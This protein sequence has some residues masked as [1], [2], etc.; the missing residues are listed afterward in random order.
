MPDSS[1]AASGTLSSHQFGIPSAS[2]TENAEE[3]AS[4]VLAVVEIELAAQTLAE[5]VVELAG[6]AEPA[7]AKQAEQTEEVAKTEV[8]H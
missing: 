7:A 5:S 6:L 4:A 8:V 2:T 3:K 1:S